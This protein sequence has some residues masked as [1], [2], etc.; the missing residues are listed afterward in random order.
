ML[1]DTNTVSRLAAP[2]QMEF[3]SNAILLTGSDKPEPLPDPKR[4]EASREWDAGAHLRNAKYE[5]IAEKARR[6]NNKKKAAI[7][8]AMEEKTEE[9]V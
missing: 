9:G 5:L 6:E 1:K 7:K 4:N 2:E 3:W 8:A